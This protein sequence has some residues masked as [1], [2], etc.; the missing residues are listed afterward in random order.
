MLV[1][2]YWYIFF[3]LFPYFILL[4]QF[5]DFLFL[6]SNLNILLSKKLYKLW[7]QIEWYIKSLYIN[8]K[9]KLLESWRTN[10]K[11]K[12]LIKYKELIEIQRVIICNSQNPYILHIQKCWLLLWHTAAVL[13]FHESI[14]TQVK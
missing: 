12:A 7:K 9:R 13:I 14:N 6:F 2:L 11:W 4:L 5:V 1:F 3:N 8:K 10:K